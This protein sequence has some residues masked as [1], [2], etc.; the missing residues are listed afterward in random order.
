MIVKK[1]F[2]CLFFSVLTNFVFAQDIHFSQPFLCPL[3]LNPA[4][5]GNFQGDYRLTT[6]YR[7]QWQSIAYGYQTIS[8]TAE[9][10]MPIKRIAL[11]LSFFSDKAGKSKM[12]ITNGNL[13]VSYTARLN[14]RNSFVGGIQYGLTQRHY[15]LNDLKWDSQYNGNEY[16]PS[17]PSGE[18]MFAP[19]Y[20]YM[21]GSMGILWNYL[22]KIS[23]FKTTNGI[24]IFH[25][26]QPTISSTDNVKLPY[27]MVLHSSSQIK[28]LDKPV[29]IIPQFYFSQ[30][31]PFREIIAG[32][33]M[34]F[35]IGT[36]N[37]S[38]LIYVD[39]FTSSAF[40]IGIHHRWRDALIV[41]TAFELKKSLLLSLSY[42]I[43]TSKL[44]TASNFRGGAE[45]SII[46]KGFIN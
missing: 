1:I 9:L 20:L 5:T 35:V 34:K 37:A 18:V 23:E 46:Y 4:N 24:A 10:S 38:E 39:K 14:S 15:N 41:N 21:D 8:G 42:D 3:Y 22:E 27:K 16:D 12:G 32:G 26:N 40:F 11:G 43:N 2:V 6:N 19:N 36:D 31:G 29:Y 33:M 17:I 45:V 7:R 44:R 13:S 25:L 28:L 30:Q